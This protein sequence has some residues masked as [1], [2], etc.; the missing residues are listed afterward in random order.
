MEATRR[1]AGIAVR[2]SGASVNDSR[3]GCR[4]CEEQWPIL[5]I[6]EAHIARERGNPRSQIFQEDRN[7]VCSFPRIVPF[8]S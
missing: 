8:P 1:E 7:F 5:S 6:L 3:T 2:V 4:T